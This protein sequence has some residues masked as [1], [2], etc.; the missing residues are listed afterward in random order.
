[1]TMSE[2]IPKG[3]V[4]NC[5]VRSGQWI[6]YMKELVLEFS[7]GRGFFKFLSGGRKENLENKGKWGY[8]LNLKGRK[9]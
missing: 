3:R 7:Y 2:E 9:S 4:G 6:N 1:M 8:E 5:I